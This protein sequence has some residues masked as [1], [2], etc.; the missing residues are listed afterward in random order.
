MATL[1]IAISSD[2]SEESVGSIVLRVILFGTIPIEI[3]IV[4]DIPVDLPT[5]PKLPAVSPFLCSDD[6]ESD[7]KSEPADELPGLPFNSRASLFVRLNILRLTIR[8]HNDVVSRCMAN[9][10]YRPSSP[11]GWSSLENVNYQ[12][13]GRHCNLS[14]L[15]Y[16]KLYFFEYEHVAVNSTRHGLDTA[17]IGKPASFS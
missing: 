10:I 6:S 12:S 13:S 11:L 2:A 5:A 3:P 15:E 7:S 16:L 8:L 14:F 4:L 1:V 17:S 9:I